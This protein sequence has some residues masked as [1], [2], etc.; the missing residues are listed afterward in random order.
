MVCCYLRDLNSKSGVLCFGGL[1]IKKKRNL[2]IYSSEWYE[3]T[4][5]QPSALIMMNRCVYGVWHSLF[6]NKFNSNSTE[7]EQSVY[8]R[9]WLSHSVQRNQSK[10]INNICC[11]AL[12]FS[13]RLV[14][15]RMDIHSIADTHT[16][17]Y[18]IYLLHSNDHRFN[19]Q[20][21]K[22]TCTLTMK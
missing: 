8:L 21:F 22:H 19:I 11:D 17:V 1:E 13:F 14:S 16:Q 12:H 9:K 15:T 6:R 2:F 5:C 3:K 20:T 4:I 7:M 18:I 10:I